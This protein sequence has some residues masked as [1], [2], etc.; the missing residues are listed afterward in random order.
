MNKLYVFC[1]LF[2]IAACGTPASEWHGDW[3]GEVVEKIT[4][5]EQS[6]FTMTQAERYAHFEKTRNQDGADEVLDKTNRLKFTIISANS[7][8]YP[9]AKAVTI[10]KNDNHQ[11]F[12]IMHIV[13]ENNGVM[14]KCSDFDNNTYFMTLKN[15]KISVRMVSGKD[16]ELFTLTRSE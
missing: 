9:S 7:G 6:F 13:A 8:T 10:D 1:V 4:P 11:G 16:E 15:N 14:K 3:L 12:C 2:L 5:K